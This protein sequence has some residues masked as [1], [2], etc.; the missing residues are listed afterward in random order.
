MAVT[1][2]GRGHLE[3]FYPLPQSG[4]ETSVTGIRCSGAMAS[5][6]LGVLAVDELRQV[7]EGVLLG[8]AGPG[9]FW[10]SPAERGGVRRLV[11]SIRTP[12]ASTEWT[13]NWA[14]LRLT[15]KPRPPGR[16]I[17][18]I[19]GNPREDNGGVFRWTN[20]QNWKASLLHDP[21]P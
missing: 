11:W 7:M 2:P 20:K 9:L 6:R 15:D 17:T 14:D 21:R 16:S 3:D 5:C 8:K 10:E 18:T 13:L 19:I 1:S 12:P 4:K